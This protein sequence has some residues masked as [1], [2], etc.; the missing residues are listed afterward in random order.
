VISAETFCHALA[1]RGW[2]AFSGVPCSFFSGPLALLSGTPGRYVP[3]ANEG[4][5]LAYAAGAAATGTRSAV[6]IQNSGLGN[7]V[8]PLTSLT[9]TYGLPVLLLVSLRGWPDPAADEPQHAVM[10]GSTHRLLD[11]LGVRHWTLD[12]DP[13][14][15][16][17]CLDAAAAEL[18]AGRCAAVLVP[19]GTLAGVPAQALQ[20]G[21]AAPP[22]STLTREDAVEAVLAAVPPEAA[23]VCTT[24]LISR[25]A[26]RVGDRPG[27]VYLQGSMGHVLAFSLGLAGQR[28]D[29]PVVVLDGDGSLLMHLGSLTTAGATAPANLLHVVV[30]NSSYES[31]GG[32][33]TTAAG[34]DLPAAARA[35]GYRTATEATAHGDVRTAVRAA[36]DHPGPHFVRVPV[37]PSAAGPAPRVTAVLSPA[38]MRERF[39]RWLAGSPDRTADRARAAAR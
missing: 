38:G 7:L 33:P 4:A 10:G 32:Q 18:D 9:M 31:T 37:G 39:A 5:A 11:V 22:S 17:R 2:R 21:L 29:L 35:A 1:Q 20:T 23:V 3:A 26:C 6:I 28:P 24:G 15:L 27:N 25:E 36:L 34:T 12:G 30:D 19:R 16:G 13:A 14:Q 8:N